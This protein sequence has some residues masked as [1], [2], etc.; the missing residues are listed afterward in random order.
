MRNLRLRAARGHSELGSKA[1][2]CVSMA[3]HALLRQ[4]SQLRNQSA[5]APSN[6]VEVS[7][8]NLNSCMTKRTRGVGRG[9]PQA[10]SAVKT[11]A[12]VDDREKADAEHKLIAE[13]LET[14]VCASFLWL[15]APL[16]S[17]KACAEHY[18]AMATTTP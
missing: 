5:P 11:Q 7:I 9:R 15:K 8:C 10:E 3:L 4:K 17:G 13:E 16:F 2:A 18:E 6:I 1:H 14:E 12:L